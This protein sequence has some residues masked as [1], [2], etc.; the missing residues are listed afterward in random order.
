VTLM[1]LCH[2][3]E[4]IKQSLLNKKLHYL[5]NVTFDSSIKTKYSIK[6][7]FTKKSTKIGH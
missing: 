1:Q 6:L 7:V 4:Y 3:E 5:I 2:I